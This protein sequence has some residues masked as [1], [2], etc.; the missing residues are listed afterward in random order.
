MRHFDEYYLTFNDDTGRAE[1]TREPL[2]DYD[3]MPTRVPTEGEVNAAINAVILHQQIELLADESC[4]DAR[5]WSWINAHRMQHGP[6]PCGTTAGR[7]AQWL[8][9]QVRDEIEQRISEVE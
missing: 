5:I 1:Y 7:I 9:D 8:R 3:D 6:V 2:Y 4:P